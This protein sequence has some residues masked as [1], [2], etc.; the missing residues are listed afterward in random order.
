MSKFLLNS[1]DMFGIYWTFRP[2]GA[3]LMTPFTRSCS[4]SFRFSEPFWLFLSCVSCLSLGPFVFLLGF[5]LW[6]FR[7]SDLTLCSSD[8]MC[9]LSIISFFLTLWDTC[10]TYFLTP[11]HPCTPDSRSFLYLLALCFWI[12]TFSSIWGRFPGLFCFL[13]F[14]SGAPPTTSPLV[15]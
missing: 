5:S 1:E 10:D 4:F 7:E 13:Y 11:S 2:H 14:S 3:P 12:H 8:W 9:P 15:T 6:I